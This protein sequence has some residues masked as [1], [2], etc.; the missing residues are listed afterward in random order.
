[1][2]LSVENLKFNYGPI[3]VLKGIN[4]PE[5]R[6]GSVTAIIG[7][8][9]AGKT[10][11]LKCLAGFL[12]PVGKI[13]LDGKE[14]RNFK[15]QDITKHVSYL[16]QDGLS[17][18]VITAFE[19]ILLARQHSV[20]WR[21]S[22]DDLRLV[23][24]VLEELE[25]DEL[26]MKYLY[27]LSG[28]QKQLVSIAQTLV[29]NPKVLLMDEP[30]NGLD[31]QRQLEVLELL[32][33]ETIEKGI[34]TLVALHDLNLASRYADHIVVMSNGTVYASGKVASVLTSHMLRDVYGVEAAVSLDGDGIPQINAICSI[35]K[36]AS[37]LSF[38]DNGIY[39]HAYAK[40]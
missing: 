28:G 34:T 13:L 5:A 7:P 30:T 17:T 2:R 37:S 21:V 29:R 27:E 38:T 3:S 36:K 8:N 25:I 9:A 6:T 15:K 35:R 16:P 20:T 32:R 33:K 22:N 11:F 31:L 1:M 18:A 10:T 4:M 23:A 24:Q 12:N 39:S 19:A 26:A 14:L 40:Q